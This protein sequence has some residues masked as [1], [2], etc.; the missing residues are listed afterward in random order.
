MRLRH[1]ARMEINGLPLHP[2]VVHATVFV[3][4]LAALVAIVYVALARRRDLFRWP[5]LVLAVVAAVLVWVTANSGQ[6]LLDARF[7]GVTGPLQ[8][9]IDDHEELGEQL[10]NA[11]WIFAAIAVVTTVLHGR[12]PAAVRWLLWALLLAGSIGVLV[13]VFL[14]GESGARAVWGA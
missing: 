6:D 1:D 2:L 3:L 11:T 10:R 4:P 7:Q 14:A 13:L 12:G 5:L 8:E 9:Q